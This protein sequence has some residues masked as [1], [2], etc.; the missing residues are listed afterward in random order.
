MK[1]HNAEDAQAFVDSQQWRFA[2]TMPTIP[3]WYIVLNQCNDKENFALFAKNIFEKG[4]NRRWHSIVR[5]YLD[6]DKYRYWSMDSTA[7]STDLINRELISD[8]KCKAIE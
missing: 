5:K 3:H 8:S 2:K 1:L 4:V 7:E 6:I